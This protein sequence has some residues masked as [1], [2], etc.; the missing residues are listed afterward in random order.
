MIMKNICSKI[1]ISF[2]RETKKYLNAEKMFKKTIA[3]YRASIFTTE[4]I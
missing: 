2:E 4:I 3:N 1:K